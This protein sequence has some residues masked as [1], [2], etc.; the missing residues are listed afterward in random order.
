MEHEKHFNISSRAG[1]MMS[2]DKAKKGMGS[3][4]GVKMR[5]EKWRCGA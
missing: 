4:G 2:L 5:N 3:R 1:K